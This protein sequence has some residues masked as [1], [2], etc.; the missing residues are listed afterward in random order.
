[1]FNFKN[2]LKNNAIL[3][4]SLVSKSIILSHIY[5]YFLSFILEPLPFHKIKQQVLKG[6]EF[7][8]N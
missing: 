2:F 1:M 8:E 4:H 5:V 7:K 6:L 3:F